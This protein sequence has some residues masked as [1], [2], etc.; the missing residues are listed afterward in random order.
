M[1]GPFLCLPSLTREH[2]AMP[3]GGVRFFFYFFFLNSYC[4]SKKT[5]NTLG[6]TLGLRLRRSGGF[7]LG[8]PKRRSNST[9]SS[10]QKQ[11]QKRLRASPKIY[12]IKQ[13]P[14]SRGGGPNFLASTHVLFTVLTCAQRT[15]VHF[16]SQHWLLCHLG[17]Y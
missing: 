6:A 16:C 15:R 7:W 3:W 17:L 4:P 12:F 9:P 2:I 11:T 14:L 13:F 10:T 8:A 1:N 5:P